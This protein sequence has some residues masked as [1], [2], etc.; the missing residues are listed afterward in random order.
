MAK[1]GIG[2]WLDLIPCVTCR[3]YWVWIFFQIV[4]LDFE[5]RMAGTNPATCIMN[6]DMTAAP[7]HVIG[8]AVYDLRKVEKCPANPCG[9]HRHPYPVLCRKLHHKPAVYP[10]RIRADLYSCDD[11]TGHDASLCKGHATVR[12]YK[13]RTSKGSGDAE[14]TAT[15]SLLWKTIPRCLVGDLAQT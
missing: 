14:G 4:A 7:T 3:A 8:T 9:S 12:H 10:V 11:R 6:V 5:D 2:L 13:Q 1:I 15:R